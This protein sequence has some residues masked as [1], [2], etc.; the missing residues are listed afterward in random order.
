[1]TGFQRNWKNVDIFFYIH[2]SEKFSYLI[3][4][5]CYEKQ[6]QNA[7]I[8]GM[9][10]FPASPVFV[11]MIVHVF[12]QRDTFCIRYDQSSKV[13]F[14]INYTLNRQ[15]FTTQNPT[16][17]FNISTTFWKYTHVLQNIINQISYNNWHFQINIHFVIFLCEA[18]S[19]P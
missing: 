2:F 5:V 17:K 9:N 18:R 11:L 7:E 1:M 13:S 4:T 16:E 14:C 12:I 15:K 10:L 8:V 19:W 3:N 6:W